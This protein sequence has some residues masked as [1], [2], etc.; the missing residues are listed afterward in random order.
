MLREAGSWA[1]GAWGGWG[2]LPS[3]GG[4]VQPRHPGQGRPDSPYFG[5]AGPRISVETLV[6]P[7]SARA[8][9]DNKHTGGTGL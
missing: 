8:A 5:F 2:H 7:R 4:S 1:E 6:L 3:G 9:A